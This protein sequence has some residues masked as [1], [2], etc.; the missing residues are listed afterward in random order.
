MAAKTEEYE[1]RLKSE[2]KRLQDE[3]AKTH[4]QLTQ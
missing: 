4:S 2:V 3:Q 1:A